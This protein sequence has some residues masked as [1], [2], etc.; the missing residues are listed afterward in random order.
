MSGKLT[1]ENGGGWKRTVP[2]LLLTMAAAL[3][4]TW[5]A[6]ACVL[7]RLSLD[8]MSFTIVAVLIAYVLFRAFYPLFSRLV[9]GEEV[10]RTVSWT[11]TEEALTIGGDVIP[12]NTIR[13]VHCWPNR[14]AL[15]NRFAGWTVNIE[16]TGKNRLLRSVTDE[17][18]AE[19]SAQHLREL[20]AAL[21]YG[22]RWDSAGI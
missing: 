16:T 19:S 7:S 6:A 18:L 13:Q 10:L 11:L 5:L 21:G 8:G 14:D 1:L 9:P 2:V 12:R 4:L 15:G 22:S 3:A 17:K 20:V